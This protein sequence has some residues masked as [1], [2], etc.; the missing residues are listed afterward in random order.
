LSVHDNGLVVGKEP[1]RQIEIVVKTNGGA[2]EGTVYDAQQ[3]T[4]AGATVV[5]VPAQNRRQN[6][7]LFKTT[8][9]GDKGQFGI[10]AIAPGQYKLFAWESIPTGAHQN[11]AFVSKYE[12]RGQSISVNASSTS[13]AQLTVIPPER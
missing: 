11:A 10:R 4:K 7:A 6:L 8:I 2:M 3:Q 13:A 1:P 9:S 5:L 12:A